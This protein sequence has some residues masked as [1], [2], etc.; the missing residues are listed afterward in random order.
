M[1][2]CF[3]LFDSTPRGKRARG[4][5]GDFEDLYGRPLPEMRPLRPFTIDSSVSDAMH[6]VYGKVL[7]GAVYRRMREMV[8]TDDE[9]LQRAYAEML[10][11]MPIKSMH[12]QGFRMSS[13]GV[14]VDV[15][16][17]HYVRGLLRWKEAHDK[18]KRKN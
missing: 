7:G 16:N 13:A 14:V 4:A 5:L 15:L 1:A 2:G 18:K 6:T 11:D 12:M 9:N 10:S 8:G 3:Q 17:R